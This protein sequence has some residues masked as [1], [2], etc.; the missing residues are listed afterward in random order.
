MIMPIAL[1]FM[2]RLKC[3]NGATL[4]HQSVRTWDSAMPR[5]FASRSSV[6]YC[7]T[8]LHTSTKEPAHMKD[9]SCAIVDCQ[10]QLVRACGRIET[11]AKLH[12]RKRICDQFITSSW[13]RLYALAV[14]T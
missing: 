10:I 13:E 14:L 12:T 3:A 4:S 7:R 5:T 1:D 6:N 11:S 9:Q 8:G 2:L